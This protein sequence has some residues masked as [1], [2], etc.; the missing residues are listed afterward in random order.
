MAISDVQLAR[1]L[2]EVIQALDRRV[3]RL[4]E[5]GEDAIARD[6][7]ALRAKAVKRLADLLDRTPGAGAKIRRTSGGAQ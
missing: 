5:A 2:R 4:Q 7:A 3:P 1:D 6:A